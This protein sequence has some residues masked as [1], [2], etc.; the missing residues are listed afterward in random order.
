MAVF[1]CKM[2]GGDLNIVE[3]SSVAVCEYCYTKQTLPRLDSDKKTN[4]YDRASHFRR[5]NDYDKAMAIY[6]QILNEDKTDAEAYWS[7]VLCRYGIEYVEDPRTRRRIPTVNRAQLT[8]VFADEDYKSAIEYADAEQRA[9]YATEA[10]TIDDIQK[11]IL[12]ISGKEEPFDVFICYKE[13]DDSGRRTPDSVLATELYHELTKEGFKVFFSRI[14][15]EDKLGTAYEP[16][17]FAALNSSKVMV[18]LGTK[19][20]YFNA[21]WVK[22][23]WSRYLALIK[24]GAKKM[25]IPAYRDMDPYDLPEEFSHLQAQDMSKLGFMQDLTR[26]IKKIIGTNAPKTVVNA[27]A[28]NSLPAQGAASP[29]LK[30]AF[31][32]LEDGEWEEASGFCEQVLNVEPENAEAYLGK[33]MAELNVRKR[34]EL[35]NL[36]E[37]FANNKNYAKV[38]RFSD[39]KLKAELTG[40]IKF[41]NERNEKERIQKENERNTAIYNDAAMLMRSAKTESDYLNA[42]GKFRSIGGFKDA[43]LLVEQC[44][45]KAET[46]RIEAEQTA[47][48]KNRDSAVRSNHSI[49]KST[50]VIISAVFVLILAVV[51]TVT[52]KNAMIKENGT[53]TGKS[54]VSTHSD[55]EG[56]DATVSNDLRIMT[57]GESGH[58]YSFGSVIAQHAQSS[59]GI[60]ITAVPSYGGSIANCES[61]RDK[62]TELA[63]CQSDVMTY[64]YNGDRL[65]ESAGAVTDFSVVAN[66]Y[67]EYIQIVTCDKNIRSAADLKGKTVSIGPMGSAAYFNALD[68]LGAY[69]I[70]ESDINPIFMTFIDSMENLKDGTIDAAFCVAS[71]PTFTVNALGEE[72]DFYLVSL[73]SEHIANLSDI[74]RE[75]VIKGGTYE[76]IRNDITTVG[77]SAVLLARNDVSED[78]VYALVKDIFD[79]AESQK[80]VND[81]YGE[82]DLEF[83]ASIS[84][85]P[86]HPGAAA[87]YAEKGIMVAA[88]AQ[89]GYS[90][91]DN[92]PSDI[93]K[94]GDGVMTYAEYMAAEVDAEVTIEAYIQAVAY[95]EQYGYACLYLADA[96]GAYYVYRMAVTPEQAD[97][98]VKGAKVKVT[99][100]KTEWSGEVEIAENSASFEI[101]EGYYVAEAK[102][103]TDLLGTEVLINDMNKAVVAKGLTV[104]AKEKDENGNELA[105]FYAWDNSGE[106]GSDLYFDASIGD[107]TYT[108]TVETDE[109]A[110]DSDVYATVKALKV[111]DVIDIEGFLYWYEGAQIHVTNISASNS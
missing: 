110:A 29:L 101:E 88:T 28:Q 2:C 19:P 106:E 6:E 62:E 58:Y 68:I 76:N 18:A 57:G 7:L 34:G 69:G 105:F 26:G 42:A 44:R 86:Y 35:K 48:A 53:D 67:F 54:S 14:T 1:K 46:K 109:C 100:F 22:N 108:F 3:D 47:E 5:N 85:V 52:I 99:G 77:V 12:E 89:N 56:P 97:T 16:Y 55:S 41:I 38:Y 91:G 60:T 10:K 96:D 15:L 13:T 23:E 61:L 98:L 78:A 50:V 70:Y 111:G 66:L 45:Q 102:D 43:A 72:K 37:P 81:K 49:K 92:S 33:L 27:A 83:A 9:V 94:K 40:Y 31:I 30:R 79:S 80:G 82:L 73:D 17:I 103:I 24:N 11:G 75:R 74:Y 25:L 59:T 8:S 71:V 95:N 104:V 107:K 65:F 63:F 36:S 84:T 90:D 87:F 51:L 64:A 4:L 39:E 93:F 20:E 21:V 32:S